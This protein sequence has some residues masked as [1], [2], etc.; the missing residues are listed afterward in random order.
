MGVRVAIIDD[1]ELFREG[2]RALLRDQADFELVGEANDAD[3]ATALLS[4]KPVDVATVD[5]MLKGLSGLALIRRLRRTNPDL[6]LLVISALRDREYVQ[7]AIGAG[8]L[9]YITKDGSVD[10]LLEAIRSVASGTRYLPED[11]AGVVDGH[12]GSASGLGVLT[13]RERELFDLL[14]RG[15]TNIEAAQS[16]DISVRTVETH[17]SR[18]LR[19]LDAHGLDDLVRLAARYQLL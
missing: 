1:H 13:P 3:S 10:R 2:L 16:M 14:V 12:E 15:A 17:R 8:A 7:Q 4:S 18:I 19:K 6:K 9:G 5:L 11:L